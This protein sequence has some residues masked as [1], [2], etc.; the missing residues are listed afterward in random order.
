MKVT[1][2]E[3]ELF[4]RH[5]VVMHPR[6]DLRLCPGCGEMTPEKLE[7]WNAYEQEVR[8]QS[9]RPSLLDRVLDWLGL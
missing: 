4:A 2:H 7:F 3:L 8:K 5:C 9:D 6:S 1:Y